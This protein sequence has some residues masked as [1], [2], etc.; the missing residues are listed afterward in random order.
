MALASYVPV[1][2]PCCENAKSSVFSMV[3]MLPLMGWCRSEGWRRMIGVS[4][5][6]VNFIRK[7]WGN[8]FK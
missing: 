5:K 6:G 4:L 8:D 1:R 2:E 7:H 3:G